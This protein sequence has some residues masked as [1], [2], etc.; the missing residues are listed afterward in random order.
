MEGPTS[1]DVKSGGG[2]KKNSGRGG[3][4]N[5]NPRSK[6][7]SANPVEPHTSATQNN[8]SRSEPH[9]SERGNHSTSGARNKKPEGRRNNN[10]S[11]S[12]HRPQS[13]GQDHQRDS[14]NPVRQSAP[15]SGRT[16]K[17]K[18]KNDNAKIMYPEHLPLNECL[19]RYNTKDPNIIRGTLRVLP[20]RDAASFC[21]C[22]RGS[23]TKDVL[24]AGPLERN[25]ALD[26]DQVF[27]ELLPLDECTK[28][29]QTDTQNLAV[30]SSPPD[31]DSEEAG[32][33]VEDY[34]DAEDEVEDSVD[35][36]DEV[37][38]TWWQ[39][40]EVQVSLWDPVVPI[41][42]KQG[43]PKPTSSDGGSAGQRQGRVVCIVPPK[44][45]GSEIN[46]T[47]T[48]TAT[49]SRRI[50][51]T[52]KRLQSGTTL[53]TPTKKSLPQFMVSKADLEKHKDSP[54]DALFSARYMGNWQPNCKWPPCED[55]VQFGQSFSV[56][57]ETTA[58]L[59]E[60]QVDHGEF[61]P[62]VLDE[63]QNVVA[64]GE[65]GN[66]TESGW[67]P[68]PEMYAGRRDL[69]HRRIF[70]I[71]PT[72]AKDLDDALHIQELENGEI[73]LGVH[74]ADVSHFV[75]PN[76]EIDFEAQK[77]CTTVYLVDRG[78]CLVVRLPAGFNIHQQF[79]LIPP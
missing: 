54:P 39:D 62:A 22:D 49:V 31:D 42:R 45:F 3:G 63:C 18:P 67:K 9:T 14:V 58:L 23:Q 55:L 1:T 25:R 70:T 66:G 79:M 72:T 34:G 7:P 27:V 17:G 35:A 38:E 73:E 28:N 11:E 60:N 15:S 33:E 5:R 8:G 36:G 26:G 12:G 29:D 64:S 69:R 59:I 71:D 46:P 47:R 65:Y 40:D 77:R 78:K 6:R 74:I 61:P 24:I 37:E 50:V 53:L 10:K 32:D 21:S 4:R 20:A 43:I 68:T 48:A 51:G 57:D 2:P 52:L 75:L 30:P 19:T 76:S 44:D 56:E 16:N 41:Q 13:N